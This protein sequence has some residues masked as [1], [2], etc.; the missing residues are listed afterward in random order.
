MVIPSML[1]PQ[2]SMLLQVIDRARNP[3]L[4][5]LCLPGDS[6]TYNKVKDCLDKRSIVSQCMSHKNVLGHRPPRP[7]YICMC[8]VSR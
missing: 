8:F 2:N 6:D 5:M 3:D 7:D 1:T 4:V